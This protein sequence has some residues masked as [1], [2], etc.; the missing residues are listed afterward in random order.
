MDFQLHR[1]SFGRL[2]LTD[3]AGVDHAGVTPVR[4]FPF[5]APDEGLSL[6]GPD[7]QELAWLERLD[8]LPDAARALIEDELGPRE[9]MPR[10]ERLLSVSTFA[11]P[12]T[13]DVRTD[14]GTARFVLKAEEDIR[15]L[16]G[17]AL[18]VT[19]GDGLQF[20]VPDRFGLDRPSRRLL[21][22]F[23]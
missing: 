6:V 17:G 18:L 3:A 21:E 16:E 5:A 4:A 11:T 23:L 19:S 10:I 12:S 15:R 22:R 20:L 13:W 14:R 8:T 9:F 2:V 7:G 1:N